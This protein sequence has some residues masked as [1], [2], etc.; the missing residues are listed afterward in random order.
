MNLP[1][2]YQDRLEAGRFPNAVLLTGEKREEFSKELAVAYLCG[3]LHPPCHGCSHC[4]KVEAGIH[5]DLI[6]ADTADAVK[7]DPI[8]ALRTDAYIRPNEAA[9]KVYLLAA[10]EQMNANAQNA[11]LKL[12]EEGP[13]YA[14]FFFLASNPERLL[15]TLRSR[16]ET[17]RCEGELEETMEQEAQRSEFV[18]LLLQEGGEKMPL[19]TFC[20]SLEKKSRDELSL[21]LDRSIEQLAAHV[22]QN[23][24]GLTPKLEALRTVR[25]ACEVNIGAGHLSGLLMASLL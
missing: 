3:S 12:L 6:R 11:M 19:L 14:C 23:P 8:R 21:F 9:R 7:V 5:P 25:A 13:E 16:C 15:P 1:K 4:R 10:A 17:I 22:R 2:Y 18:T 20:V 24:V